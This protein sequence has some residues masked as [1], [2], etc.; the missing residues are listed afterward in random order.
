MSKESV[1]SMRTWKLG[2][3]DAIVIMYVA[4]RI[5]LALQYIQV[6]LGS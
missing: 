4:V 1:C 5:S 2:G 3:W 6:T